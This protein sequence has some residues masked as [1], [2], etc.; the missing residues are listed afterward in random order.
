MMKK[1]KLLGILFFILVSNYTFNLSSLYHRLLSC[2]NRI[3]GIVFAS[4]TPTIM[5]GLICPG[6]VCEKKS[7][8]INIK[9]TITIKISSLSIN[10]Q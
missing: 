4:F 10:N 3:T 2:H 7:S 9:N 6:K 5:H 8:Q 1:K